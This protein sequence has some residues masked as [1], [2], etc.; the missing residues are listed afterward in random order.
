MDG[1][2]SMRMKST[3]K[4]NYFVYCM[5]TT[6]SPR[7]FHDFGYDACVVITKGREFIERLVAAVE[8]AKPG[9]SHS[10]ARVKYADPHFDFGRMPIALTKHFRFAYQREF[11]MVW[12]PPAPLMD[13]E[14]FLVKVGSL[15]DC[16][17]LIVLPA[18]DVRT[19][20]A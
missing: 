19:S 2:H 20:A 3:L 6:A 17:R 4:T 18:E 14:P 13:L 16:A 8:Q 12:V 9:Y 7:L 11:R 10:R 5:T 1:L 15:K